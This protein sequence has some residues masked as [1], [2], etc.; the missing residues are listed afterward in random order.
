[1]SNRLNKLLQFVRDAFVLTLSIVFIATMYE[2]WIET[3]SQFGLFG[4]AVG[5]AILTVLNRIVIFSQFKL[6]SYYFWFN[7]T[8]QL[9]PAAVLTLLGPD[10]TIVGTPMLLLN[11]AVLV[12]LDRN[13]KTDQPPRNSPESGMAGLGGFEPPTSRYPQV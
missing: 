4:V 5:L 2:P 9:I 8:I 13:K 3:P 1:M 6:K 10:L 7:S 12:T 11:I